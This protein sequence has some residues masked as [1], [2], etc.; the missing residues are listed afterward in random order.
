MSTFIQMPTSSVHPQLVPDVAKEIDAVLKAGERHKHNYYAWQYARRLCG[1][2]HVSC[3]L[4]DRRPLTVRITSQIL[5]WCR[6]NPGDISGWTFLLFLMHQPDYEEAEH[7]NTIE[8]VLAFAEAMRWQ[9]EAL[10]HYLRTDVGCSKALSPGRRE[11]LVARIRTLVELLA[12]TPSPNDTHDAAQ[13]KCKSAPQK[14]LNWIDDF[15]IT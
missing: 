3:E 13:Q 10:W 14:A 5:A 8:E 9:K 11:Q 4:A 12:S 15:G 2:L 6:K 7:I 1:S